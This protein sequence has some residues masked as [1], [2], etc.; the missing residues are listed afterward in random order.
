MTNVFIIRDR[1]FELIEPLLYDMGYELIEVE[2]LSMHGR[3]VLRLYIDKEGG[4]TIDD[5]ADVSRELG[6]VIDV[7]E[8]IEHEYVLEVSSPG[9]NRPLRREKDFLKATGSRVRIRMKEAVSGQRHFTG[10]FKN[11]AK[12]MVFLDLSGNIIG[13]P[14]KDIE[15]SNMVY[16]FDNNKDGKVNS[17]NNGVNQ[18]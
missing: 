13:L 1:V 7:K 15:K 5:C 6:D 8:V 2:Y 11:C 10:V 9:L 18:K 17:T 3:W 16:D 4:V 14:L 12:G